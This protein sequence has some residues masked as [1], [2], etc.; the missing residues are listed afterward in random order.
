MGVTG[1]NKLN[2]S[3]TEIAN[4]IKQDDSRSFRHPVSV[5][6]TRVQYC[7]VLHT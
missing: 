3:I 1:H 7:K 6:Y 5:V 4:T 2:K